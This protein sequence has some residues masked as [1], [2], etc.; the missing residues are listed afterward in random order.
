MVWGYFLVNAYVKRSPILT[1]GNQGVL[2]NGVHPE[3]HAVIFSSKKEGAYLLEREE[4]LMI[5]KPIRIDIKDPSNKLDSLSRLNYAKIYTVEH[6]VKVLF[7]G[8]VAKNY[9]QEVIRAFNEANP[10]IGPSPHAYRPD[11]PEQ[12]TSYAQQ[13]DPTYPSAMPIPAG[14]VSTAWNPSST[15]Q[16]AS[17]YP[18]AT[19]TQQYGSSYPATTMYSPPAN[20]PYGISYNSN[21]Q[22][23][24]SGQQDSSS[25]RRYHGQDYEED[26]YG[27]N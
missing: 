13:S 3:D 8:R 10:P 6:N 16:Y 18:A 1:Y 5:N 7:I 21:P 17:S 22:M 9:E 2:K 23:P 26:I 14:S 12:V 20:Q 11:T 24:P 4:G 25:G 19:D 15:Q 27:P